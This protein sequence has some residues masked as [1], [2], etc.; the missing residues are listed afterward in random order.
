MR[1]ALTAACAAMAL[2]FA[3][4]APATAQTSG[5]IPNGGVTA[6]ELQRFLQSKGLPAEVKRGDNGQQY[7]ASKAD[8][9]IFT[10]ILYDCNSPPRCASVRFVADFDVDE[11][12]SA[13]KANEWNVQKR[14]VKAYIDENGDPSIDYDVNTS[15]G[16]TWEGF[17]DDFG[18]WVGLMTDFTKF[19]G[20]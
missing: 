1:T 15:P 16:K 9:I 11:R 12:M 2:T 6:Q 10:I 19:I 14:Y 20:W 13:A 17:D 8:D 5:A 18:V 7:L 3:A 4:A